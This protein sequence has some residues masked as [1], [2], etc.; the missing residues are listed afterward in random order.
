MSGKLAPMPVLKEV[1]TVPKSRSEVFAYTAD[2]SNIE[3][4]DPGVTASSRIDQGPLKVGSAFTLMVKFGARQVPMVYTVTMLEPDTRVVLEGVGDK[5]VAID[6]IRFSDVADGGTRIDYSADLQFKG[7]LKFMA[8][9]MGGVLD[10]VV[11][12][13]LDG[14]A[15]RL[16]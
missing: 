11:K 3:T 15:A 7:L 12:K 10:K 16:Q 9:L 4:W 2:F 8:P 13:A 14:L 5:L 1:R 6:D